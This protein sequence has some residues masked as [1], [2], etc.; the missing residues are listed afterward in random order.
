MK[1]RPTARP[2]AAFRHVLVP[3]DGSREAAARVKKAIALA[4]DMGARLR[5]V[6]VPPK[7]E[8]PDHG[9]GAI[10]GGNLLVDHFDAVAEA[11][12]KKI[13]AAVKASAGE[14]GVA[15]VGETMK[16]GDAWPGLLEIARNRRCD[17]IVIA[18]HGRTTA[19][20]PDAA[21]SILLLRSQE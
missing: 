5:A 16:A 4:R 8:P 20:V 13:L 18:P 2:R 11:K 3:T 10:H 19:G 21:V 17:L 9:L 6:Y 7:T 15:C 14:A 1:K 12:A